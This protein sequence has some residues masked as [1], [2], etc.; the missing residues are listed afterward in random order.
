M[1]IELLDGHERKSFDSGN[2]TLDNWLIQYASQNQ[3][4]GNSRTFV[5]V[6]GQSVIGY[7]SIASSFLG[8]AVA[9]PKISKQS[10]NEIPAMLIARL[11]VDVSHQGK[12]VGRLLL[13]F[14]LRKIIEVSEN[15]GVRAVVIH[16]IDES[17]RNFYLAQAEFDSTPDNPLTLCI[18]VQDL[19]MA[20]G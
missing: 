16:A 6:D 17:A 13:S 1:K 12:G 8:K 5:A 20:L 14:A 3:K 11:A 7:V 2:Q 19:R 4:L 10:P 15:V 9:P 18:S